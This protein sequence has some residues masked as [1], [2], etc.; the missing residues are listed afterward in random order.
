MQHDGDQTPAQESSL[1]QQRR[2]MLRVLFG[3]SLIV[4]MASGWVLMARQ[5]ADRQ[6]D[7]RSAIRAAGGAAYCDYQWVDGNP[8]PDAVPP[9]APWFRRLVGGEFLD[10][11]VAVDLGH[12]ERPDELVRQLLLLP[13]LHT[14]RA[15]G[16]GLSDQSLEVV[17]R[18]Y[19][20]HVLDLSGTSV[21]DSGVA[22]L[23]GLT[24]L[25][26]LDLTDTAVTDAGRAALGQRL[27]RCRIV[28]DRGDGG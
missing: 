18:L 17:G 2:V 13:Y 6:A 11:V 1:A 28:P 23:G 19:G 5:R 25:R 24:L 15:R 12:A 26:Q 27:P 21:T 4:G 7:A 16:S 10:H 9:G 8:V 22:L 3:V 20:L 14:L